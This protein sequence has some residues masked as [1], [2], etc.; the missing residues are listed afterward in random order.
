VIV[1]GVLN[2]VFFFMAD[3]VKHLSIR[4]ELDFIKV[5]TYPGESVAAQNSKI[6]TQLD[7]PLHGAHIL[8]LDDI[9]D[10]GKTIKLLKQHLGESHPESI[11]TAVLLRKPGREPVDVTAEFVGFDI[12]NEFVVGYGLDYNGKYREMPSVAVWRE[13]ES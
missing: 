4:V 2:G 11:T 13:D 1:V 3:L 10:S 12:P 5:S 6:I 9:L 7:R 8:L